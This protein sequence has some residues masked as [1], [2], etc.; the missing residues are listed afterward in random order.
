MV[1][2]GGRIVLSLGKSAAQI[3]A[4][5]APVPGLLPLVEVLCGIIE[6]CDKAMRNQHAA[7]QLRDRCH[8]LVLAFR[9]VA[10]QGSNESLGEARTMVLKCLEIVNKKMNQWS[11]MNRAEQFIRQRD[12]EADIEACH[13]EISA[14]VSQFQI[15]SHFEIHE[16]QKEFS[17][18]SKRDHAALLSQLSRLQDSQDF[19]TEQVVNQTD[20]LQ[21]FMGLLQTSLGAN[22]QEAE[23]VHAGISSSLYDLQ[24]KSRTL[25]PNFHLKSGEV[26]KIG[27]YAIRGTTTMDVYE[28]LY[29]EREKVTIKAIRAM[30]ADEKSRRRFQR[31]VKIWAE[32]WNRDHGEHI[33]PFY[34]YC[35]TEG[36]F[37]Y[38]VSP[39]QN[40]GDVITYIKKNDGE[41]D[42]LRL[43]KGIA[44]GVQVL[45]TMD[46][47]I[48]HGD[49]RGANILISDIGTPLLSDF[50]LSQI[51]H[52]VAG[53]PFT[54]SNGVAESYRY[55]A[56][57]ICLGKGILSTRSDVYAFA[58]TVLE[59]LTHKQPYNHIKHHPEAVLRASKGEQPMRPS[60]PAI[61]ERGLGDDLW[62][63]LT[64]CWSLDSSKRPSIQ[65]IL[66]Q[67]FLSAKEMFL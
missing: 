28:G 20:T 53:I 22:K 40:N 1:S 47:V 65:N 62:K 67:D 7:L 48:V 2:A 63:V 58:M 11:K 12:I 44:L 37:P 36:P 3:A 34:G 46:P 55:F 25:L 9:D 51:I 59:I 41:V 30:S 16:W 5:L 6:L 4:Q 39:W 27:E 29:L 43:I 13:A 19:I 24:K 21:Q 31:E 57:E 26:K 56:P 38:M 50:G 32:I 54:Q 52:D 14:C 17:E 49:L 61:I 35:Q 18:N 33:L 60:D 10:E 8:T 15:V 42:Y 64:Q 45:H 23:R 66:G